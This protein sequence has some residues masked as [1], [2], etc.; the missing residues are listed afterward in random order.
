MGVADVVDEF[1]RDVL[2]A[3]APLTALVANCVVSGAA[4]MREL[5]ERIAFPSWPGATSASALNRAAREAEITA[6]LA[7]YADAA[8]RLIRPADQKRWGELVADAQ[9]RR[10]EGVLRD[11]LGRSAVGASRLRDELGGG[12]RRVPSRRG[13]VCDCGYARDGVL[14]PLL[15]DECEQLMLRRWVAEERR[16]LRGMPAYAED[17]AQVIER[18][19]QRQTKV[20]QTRGDDLSSEA[21]G[22]RKAG[23]R[24]LGRL[25]TRHR[26]ELADLDLGRWAGFVAPLSRASTTSVRSTVQKTHRRGLGAAALT[27][28]AVRADQEGIASF[29]RYSEGRRNSRWQI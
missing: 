15:C 13:I 9:R 23:A 27:E 20:F 1:E 24:R 12:P 4:R 28:L 29:V 25:R 6:V 17:V 19:A 11:E 26:A 22:K 21:F 2:A 3:N 16:L 8:R 5:E 7:D 18:V 14:P 10:G